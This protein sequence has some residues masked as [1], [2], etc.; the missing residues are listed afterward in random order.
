MMHAKVAIVDDAWACVSSH[1]LDRLS[2]R[3]NLE[4]GVVSEDAVFITAL[5]DQ[6]DLDLDNSLTEP[7]AL[8]TWN[9]L[10]DPLLRLAGKVL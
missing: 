3:L 9:R 7:P 4:N 5:N 6:F 2:S 10:A 1:N 8:P